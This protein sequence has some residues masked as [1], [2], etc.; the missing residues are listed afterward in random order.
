[1]PGV[2]A[3]QVPA[4]FSLSVDGLAVADAARLQLARGNHL[5][6]LSSSAASGAAPQLSWQP[7]GATDW[8]AIEDRLIFAAPEGGNGL[9]ATFYPT[10]DFQASPTAPSE[11]LIDPI[12]AHYYHVSP[13]ARLNISPQIWSAVWNGSID[14][15]SNGTY[16]FEAERLSRAGL[17]IDGNLVFDDTED[18]PNAKQSDSVQLTAGRHQIRVRMQ[19]RGDGGPRL[20]LFWTPPGGGRELVPGRVLYPPL[21]ELAQ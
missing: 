4:G 21:P 11:S 18:R 9:Q 17:W 10:P 6:V 13:F 1:V 20:Y 3:V 14:V 19:D 12:L 16:R 5:I 8:Q 2:Y 15:P 7:P